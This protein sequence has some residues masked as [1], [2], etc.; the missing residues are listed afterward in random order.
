MSN[1]VH[2]KK[3]AL[4]GVGL[5]GGSL[6]LDMKAKAIADEIVGVGRTRGNLDTALTLGIVDSVTQDIAE[7]VKGADLV[8]VAVPVLKVA[9]VIEAA[10]AHLADGCIVTDVGSVKERLITEVTPLLGDSVSFVPAHPVAGTENSGAG[11]AL[12]G[13]FNGR[14]CIVTPTDSTNQGAL[15]TITELWRAVGSRVV[16]MEP[17]LHDRILSAVSHLPHVI[18]YAL[19]NTVAAAGKCA[20][21][22]E[23]TD[24]LSYSAGG[25]RDFTRIASSSPEMW[26]DICDMNSVAIVE[27]IEA[28]QTELDA[29][30]EAIETRNMD[31]VKDEFNVAKSLRDELIKST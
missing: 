15:A 5:I 24:M 17:A 13:L 26:A 9:S 11:A 28:F 1:T 25:F 16:V 18:A 21:G 23:E 22:G 19:V 31:A 30:K 8:I 6:A 3:V 12:T 2:F 20:E 27:M 4:I 29:L 14:N 7:G 10:A